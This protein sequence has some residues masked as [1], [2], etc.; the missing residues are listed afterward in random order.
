V[1][2]LSTNTIHSTNN[3]HTE[4]QDQ[5]HQ[6]ALR[7][8]DQQAQWALVRILLGRKAEKISVPWQ[9]LRIVSGCCRFA[10]GMGKKKHSLIDLVSYY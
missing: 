4:T 9:R 3:V 6:W 5:Q 10:R 8:V 1:G 7:R 2:K